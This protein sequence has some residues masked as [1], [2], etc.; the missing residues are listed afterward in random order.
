MQPRPAHPCGVSV[1]A[2]AGAWLCRLAPGQR[3][4][5][6]GRGQET[7]SFRQCGGNE[8]EQW[9]AEGL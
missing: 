1:C 9:S 7:G 3:Q 6:Q 2:W 8:G 5:H 4:Q